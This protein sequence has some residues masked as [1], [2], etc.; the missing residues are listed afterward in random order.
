M[1]LYPEAPQYHRCP[2]CGACPDCGKQLSPYVPY[3]PWVQPWPGYP[4]PYVGDWP[5]GGWGGTY[6]GTG[7]ISTITHTSDSAHSKPVNDGTVRILNSILKTRINE[8]A[9]KRDTEGL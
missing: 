6:V 1:Y 5:Q 7:T 4:N 2:N 8:S 9:I 3:V